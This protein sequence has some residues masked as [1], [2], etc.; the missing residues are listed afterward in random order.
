MQPLVV[1]GKL[2]DK[3][4][5][6]FATD[7]IEMFYANDA[8]GNISRVAVGGMPTTLFTVS[9]P[10]GLGADDTSVYWISSGALQYAPKDGSGE[11]KSLACSKG[12]G[13]LVTPTSTDIFWVTTE[14]PDR[15][16]VWKAPRP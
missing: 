10:R 8:V 7:G 2:D 11:P 5:N 9:A 4:T 15:F 6:S 3:S 1:I 13:V 14:G 16:A 12:T